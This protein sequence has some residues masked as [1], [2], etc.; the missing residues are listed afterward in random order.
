[1]VESKQ[2]RMSLKQILRRIAGTKYPANELLSP[3]PKYRR[4][5]L[6]AVRLMFHEGYTA[7]EIASGLGMW[8]DVVQKHRDREN[9]CEGHLNATSSKHN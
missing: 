8:V 2:K 5:R 4:D 6:Q 3:D 1:M 7:S 9:M